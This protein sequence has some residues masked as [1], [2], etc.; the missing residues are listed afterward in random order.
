MSWLG[1]N[2][3]VETVK[4]D[5]LERVIEKATSDYARRLGWRSKKFV[6]PNNRSVPDRIFTRFPAQI[7]FIE[8]KRLG[9]KPTKA[10]HNE[11]TAFRDEGFKVFVVDS[12]EAGRSVFDML[13]KDLKC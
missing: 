6:S 7:V 5:P 11:I 13:E 9:L 10:Q 2:D 12:V 4:S 8:F 3:L 1:K